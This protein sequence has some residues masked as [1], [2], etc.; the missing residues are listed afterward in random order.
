M[1]SG[2]FTILIL[3]FFGAY[4]HY[5][6]CLMLSRGIFSPV[7]VKVAG[8]A[9]ELTVRWP[10]MAAA[11]VIGAIPMIIAFILFGK[12]LLKGFASLAGR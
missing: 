1:L 3:T 7:S 11:S 12:Y 8:F 9:T 10:E 4:N 5:V 2:V 6:L